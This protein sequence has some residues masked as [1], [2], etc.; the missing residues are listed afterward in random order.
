MGMRK[1]Q[2]SVS[3]HDL[4]RF[5]KACGRDGEVF[6]TPGAQDN[7]RDHFGLNTLKDVLRILHWD[8]ANEWILIPPSRPYELDPAQTVDAYSFKYK[9]KTGYMA[10]FQHVTT[11]K[12]VIK[13]FKN[14]H[15]ENNKGKTDT[16]IQTLRS[17]G[18]K[19]SFRFG[20]EA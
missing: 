3:A 20:G 12:W 7:A 1:R 10:F 17:I 11:K 14:H 9:G 15:I 18:Q 6:I 5:L 8:I 13:S 16:L 2:K 4:A 19:G